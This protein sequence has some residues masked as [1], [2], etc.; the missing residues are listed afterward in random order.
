MSSLLASLALIRRIE[1]DKTSEELRRVLLMESQLTSE[2][3]D[4]ESEQLACQRAITKY[5]ESNAPDLQAI[6]GWQAKSTKLVRE[7]Q[8]HTT[9]LK[10]CSLAVSECR[11]KVLAA[12]QKHQIVEGEGERLQRRDANCEMH[13]ESIQAAEVWHSV[14]S[15]NNSVRPRA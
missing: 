6:Q 2:I 7:I 10:A 9:Q 5:M 8:V 15:A 3:R 13:R 4:L 1:V 14:H 11:E 12:R